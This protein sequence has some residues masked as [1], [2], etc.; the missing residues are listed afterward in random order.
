MIAI[1]KKEKIGI[2]KCAVDD[3]FFQFLLYYYLI[4]HKLMTI[5]LK[6]FPFRN[7]CVRYWLGPWVV[8]Y[9]QNYGQQIKKLELTEEMEN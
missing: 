3:I 5:R 4:L 2:K 8:V 9:P 1:K 6:L 7:V